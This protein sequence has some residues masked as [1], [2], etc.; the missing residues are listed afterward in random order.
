FHGI[1]LSNY[2]YKDSKVIDE[3]VFKKT[4]NDAVRAYLHASPAAGLETIRT[5]L[6]GLKQE[7]FE[8]IPFTFNGKPTIE[9]RG[10]RKEEDLLSLLNSRQWVGGKPDVKADTEDRL[11]WLE[12]LKKQSLKAAGGLYSVGDAGFIAYGWKDSSPLDVA[13]GILYALPTP[14][15][16][17]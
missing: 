3:V 10:F 17:F 13:A 16:W 11:S 5:V 9:V 12:R 8:F 14:V 2:S 1:A 7:D 15:L 6:S 4:A